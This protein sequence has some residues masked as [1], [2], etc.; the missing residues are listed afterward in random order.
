M[1]NLMIK[2]NDLSKNPKWV[3]IINKFLEEEKNRP[4]Y[5]KTGLLRY[6]PTKGAK[7]VIKKRRV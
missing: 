7:N 1:K 3:E 5:S 4:V 6:I 2:M